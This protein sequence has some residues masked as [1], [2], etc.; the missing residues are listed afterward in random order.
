MSRGKF[1]KYGIE[2][3]KYRSIL[4]AAMVPDGTMAII[5]DSFLEITK[6][7]FRNI[8]YERRVFYEGNYPC[9]SRH[10]GRNSR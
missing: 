6:N 9:K 5:F 1:A 8:F 4:Y 10:T 7:F 3:S 2:M